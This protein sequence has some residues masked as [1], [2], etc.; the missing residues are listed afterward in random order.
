MLHVAVGVEDP[1]RRIW[2]HL[3]AAVV[4][5]EETMSKNGNGFINMARAGGEERKPLLFVIAIIALVFIVVICRG[6][7]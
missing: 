1:S 5:R 2:H 7:G 6:V 4:R 3:D